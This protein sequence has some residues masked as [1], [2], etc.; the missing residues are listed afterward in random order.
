MKR[1]V[2]PSAVAA[3][4]FVAPVAQAAAPTARGADRA[5]A[6]VVAEPFGDGRPAKALCNPTRSTKTGRQSTRRWLCD[7]ETTATASEAA[8]YLDGGMPPRD[9]RPFKT[10]V[11]VEWAD[12]EYEAEQ[13]GKLLWGPN[14]EKVDPLGMVT[15]R[16]LAFSALASEGFPSR[17]VI[18]SRALRC[19][20]LTSTVVRCRASWTTGDVSGEGAIRIRST[21]KVS[22]GDWGYSW[23]IRVT[24]GY[25]L[26]VLKR[27]RARCT[28]LD[29][30]R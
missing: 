6:A 19:T 25:C 9:P 2:V 30:V 13:V 28:E 10:T 17:E 7:A 29:V 8:P 20:R 23:R 22:F 12:G 26:D 24:D 27:G 18:G 5:A 16:R 15:A 1:V 21:G 11:S 4:L 3:A 14:P